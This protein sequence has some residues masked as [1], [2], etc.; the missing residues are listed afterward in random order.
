MEKTW[1]WKFTWGHA[2]SPENWAAGTPVRFLG[3]YLG[4]WWKVGKENYPWACSCDYGDPKTCKAK[5]HGD[6]YW[7]NQ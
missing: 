4:T 3:M 1:Y 2:G 5:L 7:K 6:D